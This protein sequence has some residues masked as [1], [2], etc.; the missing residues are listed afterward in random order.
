VAN[1]NPYGDFSYEVLPT[2]TKPQDIFKDVPYLPD[3]RMPS[4]T[5]KAR[6]EKKV[7]LL[8]LTVEMNNTGKL[9][10][11]SYYNERLLISF[12]DKLYVD[13]EMITHEYALEKAIDTDNRFDQ[14]VWFKIAGALEKRKSYEARVF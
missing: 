7:A 3:T 13:G 5:E 14:D 10:A 11:V 9:D 8:R 1:F 12:Y 2:D 6:M 4:E